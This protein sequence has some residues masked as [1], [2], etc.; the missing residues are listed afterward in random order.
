MN[1]TFRFHAPTGIKPT[2]YVRRLR[3]R[4]ISPG[5]DPELVAADNY[6][7]THS[8]GTSPIETYESFIDSQ[9]VTFTQKEADL[10][11]LACPGKRP[12]SAL[13]TL[14]PW[15]PGVNYKED[16]KANFRSLRIIMQRFRRHL[17]LPRTYCDQKWNTVCNS[18]RRNS[19]FD[20]RFYTAWHLP[21]QDAYLLE[22]TRPNRRVIAL[23][24]NAMYPFCMQQRFPKPSKMRHV[25]YN[26][27][28]SFGE[29]LPVGLYRCTLHSP[30][31]EFMLK[32]NP[33]RTFFAGRYLQ[34]S[35]K[36]GLSVDLNEFEIQ[37]FQKHFCRIYLVDAVISDSSI[38]HPLARD[39]R[40]SFA[41]RINFVKQNNKALADREKFLSTLLSS[42]TQRPNNSKKLFA[43]SALA[44]EYLTE[45][46]GVLT[47]KD[48]LPAI[49]TSWLQGWKR[50]TLTET[51]NGVISDTPNL[52]DGTACFLFNQRIVA[53]SR[54]TLLGMMEK[55]S[56]I[57]EDVE[58]C[59]ANIDSI[60]FSIPSD[61]LTTTLDV[62][63]CEASDEMGDFRID[64]VT[65]HGLWLEPGRYWLYSATVEK[66]RNRA[67]GQ[68]RGPF[69]DFSIHV[70]NRSI[71]NLNVPIR[72]KL[73][74][75]SSIS[76]TRSIAESDK[77]GLANQRL[78]SVGA[79]TSFS[80]ILVELESNRIRCIPHK[81]N[82]FRNLKTRCKDHQASLPRDLMK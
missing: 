38:S 1:G 12:P 82:A 34:T 43:S 81:M 15:L 53:R 32:Y 72:I 68:R 57:A 44:E 27:D 20:A 14:H 60:H 5:I 69:A 50:I 19:D 64:A 65:D 17:V 75:Q 9:F 11:A 77:N 10:I 54:V 49:S 2:D 30:C 3:K 55:I 16:S 74:M 37:F 36:D 4:K 24:V 62:L 59:Y 42:C 46:F 45:H 33:F 21:I 6:S 39:A 28:F 8:R 13:E 48:G 63:D 76:D 18:I 29:I 26:R 73:D 51:E 71:D 25:V 80:E 61:H 40:R 7:I 35:L 58:I 41:R 67:I 52:C 66:F 56:G 22:E 78:V 79:K 70:V 23:D 31:S 47:R